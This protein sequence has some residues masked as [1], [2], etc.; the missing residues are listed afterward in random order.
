[1]AHA[2]QSEPGK[3]FRGVGI[4]TAIELATSSLTINHEAIQRLMGWYTILDLKVM[5]RSAYSK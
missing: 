5:P 4:V 1:M 2:Q 3:I